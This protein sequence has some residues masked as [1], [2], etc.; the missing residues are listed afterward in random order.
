MAIAVQLQWFASIYLITPAVGLW[1]FVI[2]Q[3]R[4]LLDDVDRLREYL[5]IDD[6]LV[7]LQRIRRDQPDAFND[8][9]VAT[10]DLQTLGQSSMGADAHRIDHQRVVLS[11][12]D[13][14]AEIA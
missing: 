12:T 8:A 14:V 1:K 3:A 4:Q 13:G 5:R 6:G 7:N 9:C 2:M 11:V 10:V